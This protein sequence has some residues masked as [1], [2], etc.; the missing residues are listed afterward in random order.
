MIYV[1]L[2][3]SPE[4]KVSLKEISEEIKS[5]LPFTGKIMQ[6]LSKS[7]VVNSIKGPNG[8]FYLTEDDKDKVLLADIILAIDGDKHMR[9]CGLGLDYCNSIKPC[10]I[11]DSFSKVRKQINSLIYTTNMHNLAEKIEAGDHFL[12]NA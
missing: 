2:K 8:G 11:H 3:S 4:R 10:P 5:P 12:R 9:G 7:G 6:T 1:S